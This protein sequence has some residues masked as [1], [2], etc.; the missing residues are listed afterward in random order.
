MHE[1]SLHHALDRKRCLLHGD[2]L[3]WF[4][5][6]NEALKRLVYEVKPFKIN[7]FR[8]NWLSQL[9]AQFV[10]PIGKLQHREFDMQSDH[11]Y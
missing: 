4:I 2:D 6:H 5:L 8:A 9:H 3:H 1:W 7:G 11:F 10:R